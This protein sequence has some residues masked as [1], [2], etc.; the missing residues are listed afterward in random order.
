MNDFEK[1]NDAP[2]E[3]AKNGGLVKKTS[4]FQ[5]SV[6]R[7]LG[8]VL[9]PLLTVILL[10]WI[11]NSVQ[12]YVLT[13]VKNL[14]RSV[15][16]ARS[17]DVLPTLPDEADDSGF[18]RDVD[19]RVVE[20]KYRNKDY[21]RL[22]SD[23]WIPSDVYHKVRGQ[24]PAELPMTGEAY[25]RHYVN[26]WLFN[27]ALVVPFAFLVFIFVLYLLGKIIAAR[28]GKLLWSYFERVIDHVPFINTI[29]G[30]VKQVTD[31]VF[32]DNEM[33]F[34]RVV[35]VEYPRKGTWSVGFVTGESL[36]A[37][38]T[39][40]SEPVLSVLMPTSP[41]P[42]TGF[43]ISVRKSET[44]DLNISVDQAFQFVVSCGVVIP[45][46]ADSDVEAKTIEGQVTKSLGS[47]V[48]TG[49][50]ENSN[51]SSPNDRSTS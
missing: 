40:A 38:A 28:V 6:L 34:N 3:P 21:H 49:N 42:A 36:P 47:A 26:E 20:I 31:I 8:V 51:V 17:R 33:E 11:W 43:T 9:P 10:L 13:P 4:P 30:T 37:I 1:S 23:E 50:L 18:Q 25:Y 39:A 32:A 5:R 29:Y 16:V 44:V 27:P 12:S 24:N 41:M 35:A 14:A 15:A 45:G 48:V 2:P 22:P 19:G 7:G 46:I